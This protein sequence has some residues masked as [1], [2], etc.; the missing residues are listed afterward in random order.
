M[1]QE[2]YLSKSNQTK[3]RSV[4]VTIDDIKDS[5]KMLAEKVLKRRNQLPTEQPIRYLRCH[6]APIG[7]LVHTSKQRKCLQ[8]LK[9]M[10]LS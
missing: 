7:G 1:N 10:F 2:N 9:L 5:L 4:A 6:W 3:T 8:G